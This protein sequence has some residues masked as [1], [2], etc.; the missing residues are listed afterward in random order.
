MIQDH[1][2]PLVISKEIGVLYELLIK[3]TNL[4]KNASV[5]EKKNIYVR[6]KRLQFFV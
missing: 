1:V 3:C 5:P 4:I 6:P 2:V